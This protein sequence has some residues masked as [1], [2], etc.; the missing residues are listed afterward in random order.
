VHANRHG[1]RAQL[2]LLLLIMKM[3]PLLLL[4][5]LM[6]QLQQPVSSTLGYL[7]GAPA[8]ALRDERCNAIT[9][10]SPAGYTV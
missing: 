6:Q 10:H 5:P 3:L 2:Q 1:D 4:P 7:C 9:Q 8:S